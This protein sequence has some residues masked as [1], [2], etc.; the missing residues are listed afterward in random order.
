MSLEKEYMKVNTSFH[1]STKQAKQ[2]IH[3]NE[4]AFN[5]ILCQIF[6]V[7]LNS[8]NSDLVFVAAIGKGRGIGHRNSTM[9][10]SQVPTPFHSFTNQLK[11]CTKEVEKRVSENIVNSSQGLPSIYKNTLVLEK[12]NTQAKSPSSI[13]QVMQPSQ[14]TKKGSSNH[15]KVKRV[16][17]S[18][19]CKEVASL[20]VGKRLKLTFYNNRMVGTNCN[21]F[22]RHLG[23]FIRDCNMCPLGVSSWSD[24]K[25]QN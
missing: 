5:T 11:K 19:K 15:R 3:D 8:N 23:K 24:I 20:G 21:L 16:R 14:T 10:S 9:S 6:T 22:S 18:N 13:D 7:K 25:Q 12:E 2:Y 17:G 4:F 1:P